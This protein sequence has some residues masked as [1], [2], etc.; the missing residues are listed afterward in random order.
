MIDEED[1]CDLKAQARR[2]AATCGLA[3]EDA[4]SAFHQTRRLV[5]TA[6][7]VRQ[8]PYRSAMGRRRPNRT[9]WARYAR[10]STAHWTD[11]RP[12]LIKFLPWFVAT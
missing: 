3:W 9:F 2:T 6:T 8:P 11:E 5:R 4:C 12:P 1:G 10:R 7:Q